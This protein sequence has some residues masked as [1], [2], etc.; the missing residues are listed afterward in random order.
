MYSNKLLIFGYLLKNNFIDYLSLSMSHFFGQWVAGFKQEYL[1]NNYLPKSDTILLS[2][3]GIRITDSLM[4]KIGRNLLILLF[5]FFRLF[6][7]FLNK[8]FI[9]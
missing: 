5:T 8:V 7:N 6:F 4:I 1:K 9:K 3:G 2:S